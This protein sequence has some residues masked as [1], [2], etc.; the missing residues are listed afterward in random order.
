[1]FGKRNEFY[2]YVQVYI[3][4]EKANILKYRGQEKTAG[5]VKTG[6]RCNV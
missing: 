5:L 2:I 3:Q 1:M 4:I 6:I